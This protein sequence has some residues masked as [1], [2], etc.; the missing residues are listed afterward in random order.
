MEGSTSDARPGHSPLTTFRG[1]GNDSGH[2]GEHEEQG[3]EG[4]TS[5][6]R[7]GHSPLTAFRGRGSDSGHLGDDE[8]GGGIGGFNL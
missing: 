6:A 1:R 7:P 2:P 3:L 8:E 5:D 4:S